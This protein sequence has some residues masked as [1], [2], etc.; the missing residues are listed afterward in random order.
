MNDN[1]IL[2]T[3]DRGDKEQIL[4]KLKESFKENERRQYGINE[5]IQHNKNS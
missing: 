5:K 1:K 4:D 2:T 3:Y